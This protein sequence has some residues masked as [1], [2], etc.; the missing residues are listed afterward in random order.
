MKRL[1]P[2]VMCIGVTALLVP[3]GMMIMFTLGVIA[4]ADVLAQLGSHL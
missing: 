3:L 1:L 4:V 2:I